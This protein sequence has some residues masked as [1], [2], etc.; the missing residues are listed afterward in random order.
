MSRAT[1]PSLRGRGHGVNRDLGDVQV[2]LP[3][4]ARRALR[5][6]IDHAS[7]NEV[8]FF[9]R[10]T[11]ETRGAEAVAVVSE[12]EVAARGNSMSV[13]ALIERAEGWDLALHNH[14][15]GALQPSQADHEVANQLAQRGVG[16]AI[17]SNDAERLYL[18]VPP[19]RG[20]S[21][22]VLLDLEE[23][24][25]LLGPEGP[26]AR[27]VVDFESRPGQVEMAV[28]VARALNEDRILAAEAGT[29]VGKS[30]AYLIPSI[31]WA[32]R[33]RQ[34][35]LISTGTKNLQQQLVSKD[36]PFLQ[37]VLP[38]EFR[39]ALIVGRGNY[40]CRRK[41]EEVGVEIEDEEI[42]QEKER[43]G[44]V[45]ELRQL[46]DW[47][48]TSPS[49]SRGDLAW[50]PTG[51]AWE[52]LMSETDRSLKAQCPHYSE[53]FYY[54]AK[55]EA[56][57]ADIV[58]VNH[59]LFFADLAVRRATGDHDGALILPAYRRVVFDEAH[60]LEDTASQYLGL[61][62]TPRII[63]NRLGRLLSPRDSKRGSIPAMVRKLQVL[64]DRQAAEE[65]DRVYRGGLPPVRES[66]EDAFAA[67][68]EAIEGGDEGAG[69]GKEEDSGKSN[70]EGIDGGTGGG[71]STDAG[72]R[73]S[74]SPGS[75]PGPGDAVGAGA[76]AGV[77]ARSSAHA[78]GASRTFRYRGQ[79]KRH[80][81]WGDV[82][83]GLERVRA[84]LN[85]LLE[86]NDRALEVLDLA[87]VP[88]ADK[89]SMRLELE[90]FGGRTKALVQEI[91][92][93][94]DLGAE[95]SV[96]WIEARASRGGG[97]GG[98]VFAGAPVRV[99]EDLRASIF[100]RLSTVVLTSATLSVDGKI[101]FLAGRLGL[102][103]LGAERFG[104]QEHP[105][106][107]RFRE[108]AALLVPTDLPPPQ[109]PAFAR[110]VSEAVLSIVE[111]SRGRAFVLF[112]SYVLLRQTYEAL[113]GRLVSLGLNPLAQGLADR[114]ALLER[115]R[116]TPGSVLFGTDSFWEGVDVKGRALECVVIVRL[117][118]RVP[119]EPIQEARA[120]DVE[121]RGGSAFSELTIPQAVL[122]LKQGFGR[123]IRSTRDR[124]VVVVLDQRILTKAYGRIFLRSLPETELVRA[125]LDVVARRVRAFL[126]EGERDPPME[127]SRCAAPSP[128]PCADPSADSSN[129][130]SDP[131]P[132]LLEPGALSPGP[133]W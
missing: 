99:G 85:S 112:T 88:P 91:S 41:L 123:L 74:T 113:K 47:A 84:E 120:E 49:G 76:S 2:E 13:L 48:L 31:L 44:R 12:L 115:F 118:F 101:D 54:Q 17:I 51:D 40:V 107:F 60:H 80:G 11:W 63:A 10:L 25:W 103:G 116:A 57:K 94:L 90:S 64:G 14:P 45:A 26:L 97:A 4:G 20:G 125:P 124:G 83:R 30:F 95:D 62:F 1:R 86:V 18:V 32:V 130:S 106:P 19:L 108:Q 8:L 21:E 111:A 7:G 133:P 75:S 16:T 37:K 122:K 59:H 34:R 82:T 69:Q 22:R 93:F 33:N 89:R 46:V 110:K 39:H 104:F 58:V 87:R 68:G 119:T 73:S 92:S 66:I 117:P 81:L 77:H 129:D 102:E 71:V 109:A 53:C 35:V 72:A 43:E 42:V 131:R 55:R 127:V 15:S 65:L 70:D 96:R 27:E 24:R 50:V 36:L 67:L 23:V 52:E 9:A 105:S 61:Q 3:D 114:T 128:D 38:V 78:P 29:G 79:G 121:R 56:G 28:G 5:A 126:G 132:P 6:A 100:E 98:L